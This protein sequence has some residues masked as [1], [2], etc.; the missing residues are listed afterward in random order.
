MQD[1][2]AR[3]KTRWTDDIE[4]HLREHHYNATH[5]PEQAS[6]NNT[7]TINEN[8]TKNEQHKANDDEHHNTTTTNETDQDDK[9]NLDDNADPGWMALATD[10]AVWQ[11][12]EESFVKRQQWDETH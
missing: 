4:Q 8:E 6:F 7:K 12:L 11:S 2:Q 5:E 3:P 9:E 10:A 1:V